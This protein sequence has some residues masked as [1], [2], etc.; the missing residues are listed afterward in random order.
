M[1]KEYFVRPYRPGDEK[2]I[3]QLLQLVFNGWPHFDIKCSPLD[4][5]KWKFKDNPLK[6]SIICVAI[7]NGEIIG[8]SHKITTRLK[9]GNSVFL[10]SSAVDSAVH[11]NF[12]RMGVYKKMDELGKELMA[13]S[14]IKLFYGVTDNPILVKHYSNYHNLFTTVIYK[15]V[16]I[17]DID[18]HLRMMH[19]QNARLYK[20]S[21]H[22]VIF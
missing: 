7:S 8:C 11:P 14:K 2:E 12:R 18:W 6:S 22:L 16:R 5:W 19:I 17:Q 9:I 10:C 1:K 21:F 13:K 15:F 3:V 4:H 20:Y